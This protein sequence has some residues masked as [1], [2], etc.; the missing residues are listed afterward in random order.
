MTGDPARAWATPRLVWI[1][2]LAITLGVWALWP[3]ASRAHPPRAA[4][5]SGH[6]KSEGLTLA[7]DQRRETVRAGARCPAAALVRSYHVLAINVELTLNRFLDHDPNGRMYVLESDLARVRR[8]EMQNREARGDRAEPAVSLGL[9]GDA[10][11]RLVLRVN[12]GE[13]LRIAGLRRW[14]R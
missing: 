2:A 8:E 7:S 9:Q 3:S 11:Q 12:Q 1:V 13:C 10:I 6:E 5:P 4:Q 14:A